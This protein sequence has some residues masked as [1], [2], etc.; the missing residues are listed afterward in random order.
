M[1]DFSEEELAKLKVLLSMSETKFA[2]LVRIADEDEKW[3][4]L[5]TNMRKFGITIFAV[6]ASIAAFRDDVASIAS[7]LVSLVK[8]GSGGGS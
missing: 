8:G 2:R 5:W 1:N 7:W 4:W 3:E 6:V